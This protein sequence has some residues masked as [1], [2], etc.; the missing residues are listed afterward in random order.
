[1][2]KSN[3]KTTSKKTTKSKV[4]KTRRFLFL[5]IGS[6]II[7]LVTVFTIGK[8]WVEIFDKYREKKQLEEE[9]S[10]LKE[11]EDELKLDADKLQDPDYVARYAREKYL[12]SKD[13]EFI[14]K[15]PEK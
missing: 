13:G 4:K 9:L 11:K 3:V 6:I 1:M 10:Y 7:I 15:I 5:G 2:S 8:Y 14:I 12:Y